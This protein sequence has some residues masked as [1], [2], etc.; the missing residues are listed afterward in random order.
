[1]AMKFSVCTVDR[2]LEAV[3]PFP[4][5]GTSYEECAIVA[6]NLG[7]DGIELQILDPAQY[8][9]KEL[10]ATLDRHNLGCS[11]ITTGLAYL[12]E[13]MS[14]THPDKK[15]RMATVRTPPPSAGSGE[16]AELSGSGR[17]SARPQ[18]AGYER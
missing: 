18:A 15:V 12:Y 5:S 6:E 1:M 4:L 14:M 16:R 13:G 10:K 3:S 17:I 11:A 8:N 9:P 2:P 7:Y